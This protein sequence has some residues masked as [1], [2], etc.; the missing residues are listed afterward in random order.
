MAIP[1][2]ILDDIAQLQTQILQLQ[3]DQQSV[4]S[5][6]ASA[7]AANQALLVAQTAVT[8][9]VNNINA[10]MAQLTADVTAS[11][12]G[13]PLPPPTLPGGG[14]PPASARHQVPRR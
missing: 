13:N 5:L 6:Q 7:D 10:T 8:T 3:Q 1:Q 9:D 11:E 14:N 4:P 2:N 12:G